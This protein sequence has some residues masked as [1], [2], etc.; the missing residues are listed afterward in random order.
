M[1]IPFTQ[2]KFMYELGN[3]IHTFKEEGKEVD[4]YNVCHQIA[5]N[6]YLDIKNIYYTNSPSSNLHLCM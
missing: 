2:N 3:Q 5:D 6:L 4:P 1:D